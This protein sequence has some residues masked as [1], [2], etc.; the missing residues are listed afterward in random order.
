MRVA[1]FGAGALGSV[2]GALLSRRNEVLLITRGEH[3]K[4]IRENGLKVTGITEGIFHLEAE[5]YYPGGYDLIILTVK[6]YD[7]EEAIENIKREYKGE[8]I[9]T[10]Q[11]GVGIVDMLSNFDVIPGVTTHGATLISPGVVRHAGYGDTYIGEKNGEISERVLM[12]A[13]NFTECGLKTEVVND[14]ME[15]RW[16]KA[17]INACIN[18]LTAVLGVK[19]GRLLNENLREI[20]KGIGEECSIALKKRGIDADVYALALEVVEKTKENKSSMLQDI[21]LGRRT[22]V[23]YIVGPFIDGKCNRMM[24]NLVKFLE[25]N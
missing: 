23:D 13:R 4:S 9:M 21:L 10:F 8:A 19:N 15:R 20:M 11:N 22:E 7:T 24:Y 18:P 1:I 5:S 2:I 3:L 16:I 25:E 14:I 12:I 17:A 6:A